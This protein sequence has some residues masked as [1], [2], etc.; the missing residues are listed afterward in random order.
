MAQPCLAITFHYEL[1]SKF[2][3]FLQSSSP[4][5]PLLD[6]LIVL[7]LFS[8]HCLFQYLHIGWMIS[9]EREIGCVSY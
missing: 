4:L 7:P 8:L 6:L 2:L 9:L 1:P 5:V 3:D